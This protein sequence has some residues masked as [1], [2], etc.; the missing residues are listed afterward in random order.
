MDHNTLTLGEVTIIEEL[1][2][3]TLQS[4]GDPNAPKG[5]I[6]AALAYVVKKR[7]DPKYTF[8]MAEQLTSEEANALFAGDTEAVKK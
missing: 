6:M 8:A 5:K 3:L 2:G 4:L 7:E 1:S